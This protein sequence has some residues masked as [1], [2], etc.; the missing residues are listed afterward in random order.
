VTGDWWL[1]SGYWCPEGVGY[2]MFVGRGFSRDVKND[3]EQGLQ[4]LT[5]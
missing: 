4:P 1:V 2:M 3:D 5:P